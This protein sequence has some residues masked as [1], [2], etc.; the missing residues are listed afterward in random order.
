VQAFQRRRTWVGGCRVGFEGEQV[1]Y[2]TRSGRKFKVGSVDD[3]RRERASAGYVNGLGSVMRFLTAGAAC[4]SGLGAA[5]VFGAGQFVA[6]VIDHFIGPH[7]WCGV[8]AE[9]GDLLRDYDEDEQH[10]GFEQQGGQHAGV[11]ENTVRSF[12]GQAG[13]GA[14]EG[15]RDGGDEVLP[16]RG[17]FDQELGRVVKI[18]KLGRFFELE[19]V[20]H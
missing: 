16:S 15:G 19:R 14:G 17:P 11:R 1:S 5:E 18:T 6:G 13:S 4:D 2:R 10:E 7:F 8:R 12:A 9:L 20:A 3:S